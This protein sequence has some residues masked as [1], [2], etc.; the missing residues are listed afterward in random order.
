M[1]STLPLSPLS[2]HSLTSGSIHSLYSLYKATF[3]QLLSTALS[4]EILR[5]W[6]YQSHH[7]QVLLFV[8]LIKSKQMRNMSTH[9]LKLIINHKYD[10][11]PN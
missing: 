3:I 11:F 4:A 5:T 1:T 7:G 2:Q 6:N 10:Y 9:P 8:T